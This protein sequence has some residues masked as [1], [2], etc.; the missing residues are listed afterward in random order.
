MGRLSRAAQGSLSRQ[1]LITYSTK[2]FIT[3]GTYHVQHKR[4]YHVVSLSCAAQGSCSRHSL[5]TC[6]TSGAY[7]VQHVV[8]HVVRRESS[9][10]ICDRVEMA[11]ILA[12][13][14]RLK[15]L[16]VEG[17]EE[18]GVP[19]DAVVCWLLNVP[20]TRYFISETDLLRQFYLLP[21]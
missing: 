16:I 6:S 1:A 3:T 18:T 7:H 2:E 8:R 4:V 14:H 20:A 11:S 19:E 17:V 21:H 13:F 5:I 10:D 15:P 12:L 9:V